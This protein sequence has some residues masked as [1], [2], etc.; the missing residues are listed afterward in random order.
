M[1]TVCVWRSSVLQDENLW[2]SNIMTEMREELAIERQP[3]DNS[4]LLGIAAME[5][6]KALTA[7]ALGKDVRDVTIPEIAEQFA[8]GGAYEWDPLVARAT[9]DSLATHHGYDHL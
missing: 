7:I 1:F 9:R 8:I 5:A 4:E 3:S 6:A 2:Y